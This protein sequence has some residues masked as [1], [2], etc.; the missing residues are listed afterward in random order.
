[1]INFEEC[2]KNYDKENS[3]ENSRCVA[4]RDITKPAFT[5]YTLPKT[6][7]VFKKRFFKDL[8]IK[9]AVTS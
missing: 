4:T 5:F 2:A 9:S 6:V 7:V 1:M 3:L 8:F